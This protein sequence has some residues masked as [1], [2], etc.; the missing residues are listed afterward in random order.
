VEENSIKKA[1]KTRNDA[2]EARLLA[3]EEKIN[4]A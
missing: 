2:L 4:V 1:E 3:L